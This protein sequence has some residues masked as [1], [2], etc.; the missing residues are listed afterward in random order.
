[1]E[2]WLYSQISSETTLVTV[3]KDAGETQG[4]HKE[5]ALL[6]FNRIVWCVPRL[7]SFLTLWVMVMG[8]KGSL[9]T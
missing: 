4:L 9:S 5:I 1:M 6:Q 3:R 7:Q 8:P 2:P